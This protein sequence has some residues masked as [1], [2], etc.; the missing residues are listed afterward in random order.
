MKLPGTIDL[1]RR[2]T[3]R[4]PTGD[5]DDGY[6]YVYVDVDDPDAIELDDGWEW[7]EV[8]VDP[9][10]GDEPA[11]VDPSRSGSGRPRRSL[12]GIGRFLG[13]RLPLGGSEDGDG[14]G[15]GGE[16]TG[17]GRAPA[18]VRT[19]R[20]AVVDDHDTDDGWDDDEWDEE[21][22]DGTVAV[23]PRIAARRDGVAQA[24]R[25]RLRRRLVALAV[26]VALVV[27]A[28]AV[29]RSALLDVDEVL[30]SGTQQADAADIA[31]ASGIAP[32]TPL[33]GLDLDQALAR[34]RAEPWV[35][36]ATIDRTWSGTVSLAI[37]ERRPVA[38][39]NAGEGG[40]LLVDG[41]RRIVAASTDAPALPIVDGVGVAAVGDVLAP[42]AQAALD[43]A[44]A[45]TPSLRT[46]VA[47]VN[48]ADPDEV[49]LTLQP[50]GTVRFGP[51]TRI[52][53][54]IRS[55]QTVFAEVDLVCLQ[56]IDLRVPGS[57]MLTRV[58]ACA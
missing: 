48:G 24:R 39:I 1:R 22:E 43:V 38:T 14:D 58:P 7:I 17:A 42:E 29:T 3:G 26:V 18:A 41:E 10:D 9:P 23:D 25:A 4:A 15:D 34:V 16:L 54:R 36:D 11:A 6:E 35:L 46:R 8:D 51:A 47:V 2:R 56:T 13:G 44:G 53:E 31:A 40:W 57:A 19:T 5:L 33:V 21:R 28:G 49:Q 27:A 32:G 12:G 37:V 45:L 52:D 20:V 55:L 50:S 30:V